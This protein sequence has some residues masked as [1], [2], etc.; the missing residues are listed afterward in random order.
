[1]KNQ[2]NA[3]FTMVELSVVLLIIA[4]VTGF[5]LIATIGAMESAKRAATENKLNEIEK[6][7]M[8]FRTLYSR[9][10]CPSDITLASTDTS[11]G[12][13]G[14]TPGTCTG[15]TP[16]ANYVSSGTG[17]YGSGYV[18]EGGVPT[19]ALK[20]P[21]EFMFDGW[22]RRIAY[23]VDRAVTAKDAFVT[24]APRETCR[25]AV[26]DEYGT[27]ERTSGAVYALISYG[28]NGH[29]GYTNGTTRMNAG[30]TN[31]DEKINCHCTAAGTDDSFGANYVQKEVTENPSDSTDKFDDIV[32]FK[33]R[34][35]MQTLDD[36]YNFSGYAGPMLVIG[37]DRSAGQNAASLYTKA[38][39][40][41]D[42]FSNS[43]GT[44]PRG[45][46]NSVLF[47]ANN[48]SIFVFSD[49]NSSA[50]TNCNLYVVNSTTGALTHQGASTFSGIACP[51]FNTDQRFVISNNGYLVG[52]RTSQST[53]SIWRL[54][55]NVFYQVQAALAAGLT[56]SGVALS[57]DAD[58]LA[59]F[60]DGGTDVKYFV[61]KGLAF[62]TTAI[63]LTPT[64]KPKSIAFSPDRKYLGITD[65]NDAVEI[66]RIDTNSATDTFT[67]ITAPTG[68]NAVGSV[69][70]LTFSPDGKY[71]AH[72]GGSTSGDNVC[73]YKINAAD[74]F[75]QATLSGWSNNTGYIPV[76]MSFSPDSR[77]LVVA[78]N[79]TAIPLAIFTRTDATTFKYMSGLS[80]D[81]T[82]PAAV[83]ALS[84]ALYR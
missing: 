75:T 37:Y 14:A 7:L 24:I 52:Y 54:V 19:K 2:R 22:G 10:P 31:T 36:G 64:A 3:A 66:W 81:I 69:G 72:G 13:E 44:E 71:L 34:W 23:V 9:L 68:C 18:V 74:T 48:S 73:I 78:I 29:G 43:F 38:C 21:N 79:S 77:F 39:N 8:Q 63:T 25:I 62:S 46:A 47:T 58:I 12:V 1:M 41:W 80:S 6:A 49:S 53:L 42:D 56:T 51:S 70:A 59:T 82:I 61:R 17:Y 57:R 15:G 65:N 30:S 33:L 76:A 45:D 83:P 32:R 55:N 26:G 20:L 35:H 4:L 60:E 50:S 40:T 28:P 5:G 11:Y 67:S 84:V 27:T 16:A